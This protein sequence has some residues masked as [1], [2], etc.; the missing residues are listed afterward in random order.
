[1][2]GTQYS[3]FAELRRQEILDRLQ[4]LGKITVAE[5]CEHFSLSPATIRN[6]LAELQREGLLQRTHGGAIPCRRRSG[7]EPTSLEKESRNVESKRAIG[8]RAADL[9]NPGDVIALDTGTTT[10]ELA[11]CIASVPGLTV[12]TNDLRIAVLLEDSPGA[13][14]FLLGG[15]VRRGFSCTIG[16]SVLDSLSRMYVDTL[17]LAT[18]G[19]SL[20]RGFSTPSVEVA[21]IKRQFIAVAGRVVALADSSKMDNEAFTS[22]A[23]LE[24]IDLLITDNGIAPDFKSALEE[25]GIEVVA[26]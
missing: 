5:L 20:R 3:E 6:D 9:V 10:Y 8:Y 4:R 21:D 7:H 16:K 11:R 2:A 23:A 15:T 14:V 1:M 17:F 12:I 25:L 19:I 18:N 22:F 13:T 24:Q 26:V